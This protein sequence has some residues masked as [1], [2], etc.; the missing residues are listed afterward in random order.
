MIHS[1][2]L[3]LKFVLELASAAALAIWGA[4]LP[5]TVVPVIVAIAAPL[6]MFAVWAAF[7]APRASRRLPMPRRAGVELG[8]FALAAI[9]LA[10]AGHDVWAAALA[11]V[12]VLN[13]SL[14]T[15]FDQW[16]S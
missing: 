8:V 4:S 10:V 9:A 6:A 1:A 11:V 14:L 12:A 2:N 5:G 16:E 7:C 3:A 15:A 13:A